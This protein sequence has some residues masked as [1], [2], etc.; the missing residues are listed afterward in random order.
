MA[1]FKCDFHLH[2]KYSDNSDR[3]SVDEYAKLGL[4]LGF[5]ALHFAD[6]HNDLSKEKWESLVRDVREQTQ[7]APLLLHG[8]EITYVDGHLV[9][10][11]RQ[12]FDSADAPGA[13][14]QMYDTELPRIVA[15][16]DNNDCAWHLSMLP[17]ILG[18]EVL[19][20]GQDPLCA[21]M[22]SECN[23]VRTY[24]NYLLLGQNV[25][26][27]ANTD[28][29][30]RA[31]FG[32]VWTGVVHG[33]A[34]GQPISR[35]A[36]W[37][38]LLAR[39][40]FASYGDVAV[41]W[42]AADGTMMGGRVDAGASCLLCA[43]APVGSSISIYNADRLIASGRAPFLYQPKENGPHWA[44]VTLGNACA[45][46]AP[47]WVHGIP[48]H[49]ADNL[50]AQL[51]L[52]GAVSAR[53]LALSRT[54]L[55][56]KLYAQAEDQPTLSWL[57]SLALEETP[58][59]AFAG[60]D[61]PMACEWMLRRLELGQQIAKR[62]LA[63]ALQRRMADEGVRDEVWI[64]APDGA[65]RELTR[66][67]IDMPE[68]RAPFRF[69]TQ[70][71]QEVPTFGQRKPLREPVN[72]FERKEKLADI[73]LWLERAELH[74]FQIVHP[75][76]ETRDGTLYIEWLLAP[77]QLS[78]RAQPDSAAIAAVRAAMADPAIRNCH[79]HTRRMARWML[80]ADLPLDGLLRLKLLHEEPTLSVNDRLARLLTRSPR[81]GGGEHVHVQSAL[82]EAF[83]RV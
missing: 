73:L 62:A 69:V 75:S 20:G 9:L 48:A 5:D 35:D 61:L 23:G 79:L 77:H 17:G 46:S 68:I 39:R 49:G 4:A 29:H 6:H 80:L 13:D 59:E 8:Y 22:D 15:H 30:Q 36:L 52:D 42:S 11:D 66:V 10:L 53:D 12:T 19:N 27:Y 50:R 24:M 18:V 34:Q 31:L 60:K 44:M 25:S 82:S 55:D 64:L 70:D 54:L 83:W 37:E 3:M 40:T 71:G 76:V 38:A 2:T 63:R 16:P 65:E 51:M 1:F 7:L 74:E 78:D 67:S 56:L 45:Y 72:G 26:P 47:I 32:R 58:D 43:Q 41:D 33:G 28:C 57:Q 14:A 81:Q 21:Q